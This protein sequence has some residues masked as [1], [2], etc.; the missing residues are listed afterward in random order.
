MF[1]N[2][3]DFADHNSIV[4][5]EYKCNVCEKLIKP[6]ALYEQHCTKHCTVDLIC[7][8]CLA[9]KDSVDEMAIHLT[10]HSITSHVCP[11]SDCT[12]EFIS[13]ADRE[14]HINDR[15]SIPSTTGYIGKQ[16]FF[17]FAYF[18]YYLLLLTPA[19]RTTIDK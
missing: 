17:F 15:H 14:K 10:E 5:K 7:S 4:H 16:F 11:L 9:K 13:D 3:T 1:S 12:M 19:A 8:W 6:R 18:C 2:Q